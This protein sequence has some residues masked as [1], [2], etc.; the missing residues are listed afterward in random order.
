[1]SIINLKILYVYK[2]S[3]VALLISQQT[4]IST[5]L[6]KSMLSFTGLLHVLHFIIDFFKI[7]LRISNYF[8]RNFKKNQFK[9]NFNSCLVVIGT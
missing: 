9:C 3:V 8:Y 6:I 7:T 2:W 4:L 5:I 1:M